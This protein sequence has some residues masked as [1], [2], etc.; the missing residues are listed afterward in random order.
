MKN[1]IAVTLI[2]T[3]TGCATSPMQTSEEPGLAVTNNAVAPAAQGIVRTQQDENGNTQVNISVKHLAKPSLVSSQA[4]TYVVWV[5]P[6]GESSYQNIGALRVNQ[7]LE[8]NYQTSVPYQ[9][10]DLI[11]TP[12]R[13]AMARS[14]KGVTVIQKNVT[15]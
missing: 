4:S 9:N 15:L 14:P 12:E 3:L 2:L 11:V 6:S 5:K 13:S 7:D 10:F 1:I 8:G